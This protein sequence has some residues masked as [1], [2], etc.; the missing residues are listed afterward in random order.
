MRT[1]KFRGQRVDAKE[2]VYG[3]LVIY[4]TGECDIWDTSNILD[5]VRVKP[6]TVGQFTGLKDKNGDEIYEGMQISSKSTYGEILYSNENASY[7][8]LGIDGDITDLGE[9]HPI[10]LEIVKC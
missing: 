1:I 7:Y 5:W 10:E 6:E 4:K 2:W 3:S 8:I 9:F